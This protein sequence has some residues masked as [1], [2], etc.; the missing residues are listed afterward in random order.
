MKRY[1]FLLGILWMILFTSQAQDKV[2]DNPFVE[3]YSSGS[4]FL[5]KIVCSDTGTWLYMDGYSAPG[6]WIQIA[7]ESVLT[8]ENGRIYKLVSSENIQLGEKIYMPESGNVSFVLYFEPLAKEERIVS[9]SEGNADGAFKIN[10]IHLKKEKKPK[11]AV[12]CKIEGE[13]VDRPQSSRLKLIKAN[14]DTRTTGVYIPIR[15]NR[16]S[17]ELDCAEEEAYELVFID[18]QNNGAWRPVPFFAESGTVRF[19]LYPMDRSPENKIEGGKLNDEFR[20]FSQTLDEL[21]DYGLI[22]KKHKT[23]RESNSYYSEAALALME[24]MKNT[25]DNAKQD[26]LSKKYNQMQKSGELLTSAGQAL[27]KEGEILQEKRKAWTFQYVEEH[28]TIVGYRILIQGLFWDIQNKTHGNMLFDQTVYDRLY[29]EVY[30][31]LYPKHVYTTTM[32]NMLEGQAAIVVGGRY[33]DFTAPDLQG[34]PVTLSS[35]IQ[36]NV[37]LID[38]WASWCGPCRK[39]SVSLIPVYEKYK[40]KGFT[41][42]GVAREENNTNAMEKAIA[43]HKFPWLNLVELND[44]ARIWEKYGV[45]NSGGATFLVDASGNILAISPT[46]EEVDKILNDLFE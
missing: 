43:Q 33:I 31:P 19:T 5:N 12:C 34:N 23:L 18:E 30:A 29:R 15:N 36:G 28:P 16:F 45:G 21:F 6:S 24:E 27:Q 9:F 46:A 17:Y 20:L 32:K 25:K 40:D 38:L 41:I 3:S 37:A 13:V 7:P 1:F 14:G 2:I 22:Q 8:G 42:I 44:K 4:I 39:M 10:A 35:R 26:S 11:M